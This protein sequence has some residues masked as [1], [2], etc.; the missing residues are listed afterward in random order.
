MHYPI[1]APLRGSHGL[2]ARRARRTKSS[3]PKWPKAGPKGRKL[4]VGPRRGPTPL[5]PHICCRHRGHCNCNCA[6]H[7]QMYMSFST[8]LSSL[9]SSSLLIA[10]FPLTSDVLW[11]DVMATTINLFFHFLL[12]WGCLFFPNAGQNIVFFCIFCYSQRWWRFQFHSNYLMIRE[13]LEND[14]FQRNWGSMTMV[15]KWF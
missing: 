10:C 14:G 3:R 6:S 8:S 15:P 7:V 5:V 13:G 1:I 11:C 9:L 4:E 2:S 12:S